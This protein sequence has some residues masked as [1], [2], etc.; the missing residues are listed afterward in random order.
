LFQFSK[1]IYLTNSIAASKGC[2]EVIEFLLQHPDVDP[3]LRN[4]IGW[5]TIHIATFRGQ[6]NTIKILLKDKRIDRH[7]YDSHGRQPIQ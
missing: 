6:N 3:N 2:N 7:S 5:Q 4:E 1:L